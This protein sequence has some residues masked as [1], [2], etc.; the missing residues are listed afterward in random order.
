M[1]WKRGNINQ[2]Q[3]TPNL[4][5]SEG[6]RPAQHFMPAA[7]LSLVRY[8]KMMDDYKVISSGKVLGLDWNNYLVPAGLA[9]DIAYAIEHASDCNT[10]AEFIAQATNFG[11]VYG[12]NDVAEGVKNLAG[13]AVSLNEPVVASFFTDYDATKAQ[14]NGVGKPV[15]LAPQDIWRNPFTEGGYNKTAESYTYNNW[16]PQQGSTVLTRYYI[17]LPVVSDVTAVVLPGMTVFEGSAPKPGDLITF[18][19]RSNVVALAAPA[20]SEFAAGTAGDPSNAEL[21]AEFDRVLNY[22]KSTF[23]TILGR[24]LFVDGTFPKDFLEW[25]RT[26]NINITNSSALDKTAGSATNGLPVNLTYAGQS[27]PTTAKLV[28]IYVLF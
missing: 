8:D 22:A 25:V 2:G 24:V 15:G 28:R 27:D 26:Y 5:I 12:A 6:V 23:G 20:A 9:L 11:E 3:T 18:N 21:K 19:K 17:E 4:F 13:T 10:K 1:T 14:V 7:Y 16:Q